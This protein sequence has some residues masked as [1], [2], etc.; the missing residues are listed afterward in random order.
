MK[1]Y[2]ACVG[3]DSL[4][5][6]AAISCIA[7]YDELPRA[8]AKMLLPVSHSTL[9]NDSKY[10]QKILKECR[11]FYSVKTAL[12]ENLE[13]IELQ[14]RIK[15]IVTQLI[16]VT[17]IELKF[18]TKN[19]QVYTTSN[20]P[21][22]SF[23]NINQAKVSQ[24]KDYYELTLAIIHAHDTWKTYINKIY[25]LYPV[26][27]FSK[28]KGNAMPIHY[29]EILSHGLCTYHNKKTTIEKLVKFYCLEFNKYLNTDLLPYS[30]YLE[31]LPV[32]WSII[33][34]ERIGIKDYLSAYEA[35][36]L[37]E[38]IK[39]THAYSVTKNFYKRLLLPNPR[40]FS[41]SFKQ[42]L[43]DHPLD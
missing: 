30:K 31:K 10:L 2:V 39:L 14:R 1:V 20:I 18:S 11:E 16:H 34:P 3:T 41:K 37:A 7:F 27:E 23:S 8:L 35:K 29:M 24:M 21:K 42:F 26:Y 40:P 43:I 28:H 38:S 22:I 4:M 12:V 5:T 15:N 33:D 25:T 32:W 9:T 36:Y 6:G 13:G 19:L 17:S